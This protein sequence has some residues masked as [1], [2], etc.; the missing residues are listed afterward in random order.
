ML[1]GPLATHEAEAIIV[2]LP[3]NV[4]MTIQMVASFSEGNGRSFKTNTL[5]RTDMEEAAE[6]PTIAI[7]ISQTVQAIRVDGRLVELPASAVDLIRE[8]I[9]AV[10]HPEPDPG[11][12]API[13]ECKAAR[14]M[15]IH[16]LE[17]GESHRGSAF[18]E[19]GQKW[20][21]LPSEA[22]EIWKLAAKQ[23]ETKTC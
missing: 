6:N 21:L 5:W 23:Q 3:E 18:I 7:R 10:L 14:L 20:K 17:D 8:I 19:D 16:I 15:T 11:A 9:D 13:H 22:A 12:E 4:K 1:R 2:A